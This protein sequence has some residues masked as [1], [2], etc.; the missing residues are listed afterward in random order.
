[1][2]NK[3]INSCASDRAAQSVL[4]KTHD[5]SFPEMLLSS[6]DA[7]IVNTANAG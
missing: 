7:I 6:E 3:H 4:W 1:M 2:K 5:F